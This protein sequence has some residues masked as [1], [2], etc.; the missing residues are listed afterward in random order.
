MKKKL[1]PLLIFFAIFNITAQ[2]TIS[3]SQEE[4]VILKT[5]LDSRFFCFS[6]EDTILLNCQQSKS[7]F[8][9]EDFLH[10]E[11]PTT[12][13]GIPTHV[14]QELEEATKHVSPSVWD[15]IVIKN[16]LPKTNIK[17]VSDKKVEKWKKSD[18]W[19]S[20][21]YTVSKP[22]F[23]KSHTHCIVEVISSRHKTQFSF[24]SYFLVKVYGKW[25]VIEMF[26]F[27]IS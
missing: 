1:M 4:I 22:I 14:L 24:I 2:D 27:G 7:Y 23:D 20:T 10:G 11:Q 13:K 25:V 16:T 19:H 17:C 26:S 9:V 21:L 18:K 8:L 5:V 3:S 12:L 6:L 15:K